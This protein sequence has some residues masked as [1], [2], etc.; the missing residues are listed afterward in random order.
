MK[1]SYP[2]IYA[3]YAFGFWAGKLFPRIFN[4]ESIEKVT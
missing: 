3:S 4:Y 1:K 2:T